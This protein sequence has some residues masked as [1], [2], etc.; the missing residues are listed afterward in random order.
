MSCITQDGVPLTW[1]QVRTFYHASTWEPS[2]ATHLGPVWGLALSSPLRLSPALNWWGSALTLFFFKLGGKSW[3]HRW[4]QMPPFASR[5]EHMRRGWGVGGGGG[6][7]RVER[8]C[9]T[10][11]IWALPR[12]EALQDRGWG[13]QAPTAWA[14]AFASASSQLKP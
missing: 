9:F 14:C 11:P 13:N 12:P 4:A 1:L 3:R 5:R 7:W 6:I 8:S 2:G 10:Q